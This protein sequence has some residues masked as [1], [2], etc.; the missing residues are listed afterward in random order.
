MCFYHESHE[1]L[2]W[3]RTD[4][5]SQPTIKKEK[6]H[7]LVVPHM[8]LQAPPEELDEQFNIVKTH[9]IGTWRSP[10]RGDVRFGCYSDVEIEIEPVITGD[11]SMMQHLTVRRRPS[12]TC[13]DRHYINSRKSSPYHNVLHGDTGK[14]GKVAV[15]KRNESLRSMVTAQWADDPVMLLFTELV[16]G[17]EAD[18][19]NLILVPQ[20]KQ[21]TS[22]NK[23]QEA[24]R[25]AD[26]AIFRSNATAA[27]SKKR[28]KDVEDAT[29]DTLVW[30]T[31]TSEGK[32]LQSRNIAVDLSNFKSEASQQ[33]GAQPQVSV[34]DRTCSK[35]TLVL[36]PNLP[37]FIDGPISEALIDHPLL[38]EILGFCNL[39]MD[40]RVK[41]LLCG[42]LEE[43]GRAK[44]RAEAK[45]SAAVDRTLNRAL[46]LIKT[47]H[48]CQRRGEK[49]AVDDPGFNGKD[50]SLI[51]NNILK[52]EGQDLKACRRTGGYKSE[53]IQ[54]VFEMLCEVA[55]D[56]TQLKKL[57]EYVE[58]AIHAC[59]A[60]KISRKLRPEQDDYDLFDEH[61]ALFMA[62]WRLLQEPLKGYGFHLGNTARVFFRMWRSLEAINA[63]G[64]EGS[65][66][67]FGRVM[68]QICKAP[69]GKYSKADIAQGPERLLEV[70]EE[71]RRRL[72]SVCRALWEWAA[73][74]TVRRP[75]PQC[76][77]SSRQ[78]QGIDGVFGS[79]ALPGDRQKDCRR[80]CSAVEDLLC[81]CLEQVR[82]E[83]RCKSRTPFEIKPRAG[84]SGCVALY[85]LSL[86]LDPQ[87][88]VRKAAKRMLCTPEEETPLLD[89]WHS[90][91]KE[92]PMGCTPFSE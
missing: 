27:S 42:T 37:S 74:E 86:Q 9:P 21:I 35:D 18:T 25:Q 5:A 81:P 30:D 58:A 46:E 59:K 88:Q 31:T 49:G 45:W 34:L 64:I 90:Y 23:Q 82:V 68:P 54:G 69:V 22:K 67:R 29:P 4:G 52:C 8:L 77:R 92:W 55:P 57:P 80:G 24:Q 17:P 2:S 51:G 1:V 75:L 70:L 66:E 43:A 78:A 19:T 53:Y 40:M 32:L 20:Q 73:Q 10:N 11:N 36:L 72:K 83:V 14:I 44:L 41:E 87:W 61:G 62:K 65:N 71:R 63:Q 60:I 13:A 3:K 39:H 33:S 12:R 91:Y 28:T 16:N 38:I 26:D 6:I 47:R 15:R 85:P 79:D 84:N 50:A 89:E 56:S 7:K 48:R 76:C